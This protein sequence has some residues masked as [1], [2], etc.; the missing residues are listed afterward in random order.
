MEDR[1]ILVTHLGGT[2]VHGPGGLVIDLGPVE[3]AFLLMRP[4][5]EGLAAGDPRLLRYPLDDGG[6]LELHG[7]WGEDPDREGYVLYAGGQVSWPVPT[8]FAEDLVRWGEGIL[9][10]QA[11]PHKERKG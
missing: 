4:E 11:A 10:G 5:A 1:W 9:Q 2:E 8:A 6:S 7:P 3:P